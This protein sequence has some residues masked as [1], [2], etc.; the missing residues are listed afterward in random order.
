MNYLH[1]RRALRRAPADPL[2][3][4]FLSHPSLPAVDFPT[5]GLG[6]AVTPVPFP[7]TDVKG[8]RG[9]GTTPRS[10]GEQRAAGLLSGPPASF[11]RPG[12]FFSLWTE[13]ERLHATRLNKKGRLPI[14]SALLFCFCSVLFVNPNGHFAWSAIRPEIIGHGRQCGRRVFG[15]FGG[16]ELV[17]PTCGVTADCGGHEHRDTADFLRRIL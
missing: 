9:D 11:Q 12:A 10:V 5:G 6:G 14:G 7:N 2:C 15:R 13:P 3:G 16:V 17:F 4:P 1:T 8:P